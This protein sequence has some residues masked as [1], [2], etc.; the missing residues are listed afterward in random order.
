V[1]VPCQLRVCRVLTIHLLSGASISLSRLYEYIYNF[2]RLSR[3]YVPLP[4]V[5][6]GVVVGPKV[7]LVIVGPARALCLN[8][9]SMAAHY[10]P[11]LC[12]LSSLQSFPLCY[13]FLFWFLLYINTLGVLE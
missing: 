2:L 6:N 9:I 10:L 5:N 4:H 11:A 8:F 3:R 1:N 7:L 12:L 13:P